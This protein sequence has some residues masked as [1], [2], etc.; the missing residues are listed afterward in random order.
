MLVTA[1]IVLICSG[2]VSF[3]LRFL[4]ALRQEGRHSSSAHSPGSQISCVEQK[5][6]GRET[7]LESAARAAGQHREFELL[8]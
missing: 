2:A 1:A 4:V 8:L 6:T 7:Q 5:I 3:C